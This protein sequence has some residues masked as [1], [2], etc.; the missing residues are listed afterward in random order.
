MKNVSL[1]SD[2]SLSD[3]DTSHAPTPLVTFCRNLRLL[4]PDQFCSLVSAFL[5]RP[6]DFSTLDMTQYLTAS[7]LHSQPE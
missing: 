1:H 7:A 2:H 3:P 5:P 6:P 4:N